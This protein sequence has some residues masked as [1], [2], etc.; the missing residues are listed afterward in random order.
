MPF[1][2]LAK[3][4][5]GEVVG[6]VSSSMGGR[7]D[8][9]A[10]LSHDDED[11]A[12]NVNPY[13]D[14]S[15][16]KV[17]AAQTLLEEEDGT[18]G[19]IPGCADQIGWIAAERR[20]RSEVDRLDKTKEFTE[21]L[22]RVESGVH[23][24]ERR[25]DLSYVFIPG[26]FCSHYPMYLRKTRRHLQKMGLDARILKIDTEASVATNAKDVAEQL[27][28]IH[29]KTGKRIVLLGHSKGGCDGVAA[30][31]RH[32]GEL[33]PFVVGMIAL[34]SPLGGT[35]LATDVENSDKLRRAFDKIV[36]SMGGDAACLKDMTY[37]RRKEELQQFPMPADI[38]LVSMSSALT[39]GFSTLRPLQSY[40]SRKY[41][42][43]KNDGMVAS[44]DAD[45]PGSY[46]VYLE[47]EMDHGG[48][49]FPA[50]PGAAA[51]GEH[52]NEAVIE[53]FARTIPHIVP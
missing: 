1:R 4:L 24:L 44:P 8:P 9:H 22:V 5:A 49:A 20:T 35:P 25:W 36:G 37:E 52:V 41:E 46:R 29:A 7:S 14:V 45:L 2:A 19:F 51:K 48:C 6:A 13:S 10:S 26:L 32:H 47:R 38:P 39:H 17:D 50:F 33:K 11:E 12:D 16:E 21:A 34:Q 23:N 18:R 31:A 27:K 43:L 28:K 40:M 3:Q 42:G 30:L 15:Q 53:I